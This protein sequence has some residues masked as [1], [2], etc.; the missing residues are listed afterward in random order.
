MAL[1]EARGLIMERRLEKNKD[2]PETSYQTICM[3]LCVDTYHEC[4]PCI[5]DYGCLVLKIVDGGSPG[6]VYDEVYAE[7]LYDPELE[8]REDDA[9]E[10]VANE[11][12]PSL[13]ATIVGGNL[14]VHYYE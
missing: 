3:E 12:E 1:I 11:T 13:E 9:C 6:A 14:V 4:G 8:G 2:Y 7:P 5:P 10:M